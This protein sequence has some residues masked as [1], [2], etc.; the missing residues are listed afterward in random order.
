M[1]FHAK[2]AYHAKILSTFLLLPTT[3]IPHAHTHLSFTR[4]TVIIKI[5]RKFLFKPQVTASD[6]SRLIRN[7]HSLN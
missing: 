3:V 7:C 4:R 1:I 6:L 2:Q 5:N